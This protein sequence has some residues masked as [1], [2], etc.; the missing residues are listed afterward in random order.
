MAR[1]QADIDDLAFDLYGFSEAD[2]AAVCQS[3]PGDSGGDDD[4]EIDEEEEDI[5]EDTPADHQTSLLSWAVGVAF[6]RFDWRLATGER[7]APPE[8]DPFDPLPAKSPGMLPDDAHPFHVHTGILV[9][10]L[11]HPH[12]LVHLI[13]EVLE[14]VD[15]PVPNDVRQWLQKDFFPFHLK[16]YSKSRRKTPIYW[17]LSTPSGSYTLWIYYPG[18]TS[19]TLYSAINDFLEGPRGKLKQVGDEVAS[20]RMKGSG[21]SHEDEKQFEKYQAL[22]L[23]LI[24]LRDTLLDIARNFHPNQ[25]DGVQ[26]I[27]A[28][29]LWKLF[30]HRPW[31]NV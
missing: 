30:Q 21:R 12:D 18:L 31:Q 26:M 14:R 1:I 29:P 3:N 10:D 11:G 25:D 6:G 20:L 27:T 15:M 2:R 8:P 4:L 28:A 19:Q 24:E 23:E 5:Q 17:P 16:T 7:E 9:D 13:E 22:E